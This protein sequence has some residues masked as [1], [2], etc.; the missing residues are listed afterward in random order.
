MRCI[1]RGCLASPAKSGRDLYG[2]L[3][4]ILGICWR[5]RTS[6]I[7]HDD[8]LNETIDTLVR[9]LVAPPAD[10]GDRVTPRVTFGE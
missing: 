8:A 9:M 4:L 5:P 2:P 7:D 1:A 3:S 6:V 10:G